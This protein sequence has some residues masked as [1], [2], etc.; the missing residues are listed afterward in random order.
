[1]LKHF[2]RSFWRLWLLAYCAL[3]FW[4]SDQP[5]LL[6]SLPMTGQ[7]KVVHLLAYATM[8]WLCWQSL[9]G[10]PAQ[11]AWMVLLFCLLFGASDEWHQ[12]FVAGRDASLWDW[13]ADA[14]G[15]MVVVALRMRKAVAGRN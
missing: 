3:I 2:P 7:D 13:L 5:R 6:V 10:E 4:L 15:A 14:L 9:A 8:A 11:R 12:S 1:M